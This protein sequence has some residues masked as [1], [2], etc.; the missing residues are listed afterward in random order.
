M[1][2]LARDLD[3]YHSPYHPLYHIKENTS[4]A[5]IAYLQDKIEKSNSAEWLV[6]VA[7]DTDIVGFLTCKIDERSNPNWEIRKMGHI[8]KVY[9]VS[10][11]LRRGIASAMLNEALNWLKQ[12]NVQYVDIGVSV[13]NDGAISTWAAMRFKPSQYN[14]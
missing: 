13:Q 6:L 9:V 3:L 7:Q 4:D 10:A 12:N 1:T 11:Y 2:Q 5:A 14:M 8:I